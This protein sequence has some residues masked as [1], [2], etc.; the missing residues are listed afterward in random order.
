MSSMFLP[1]TSA[2]A[3]PSPDI[4]QIGPSALTGAGSPLAVALAG[5]LVSRSSAADVDGSGL[6][7]RVGPVLV[8]VNPSPPAGTPA[9]AHAPTAATV[10]SPAVLWRYHTDVER[11]ALLD[12]DAVA[13][14]ELRAQA[15]SGASSSA[16]A[17]AAAAAK[18]AA[19]A[20]HVFGVA[21]NALSAVIR[22]Y[23]AQSIVIVGDRGSGKRTSARG[24]LRYVTAVSR[25]QSRALA[26]RVASLRNAALDAAL[27]AARV[28]DPMIVGALTADRLAAAAARAAAA[29]AAATG[30][31]IDCGSVGGTSAPHNLYTPRSAFLGAHATLAATTTLGAR[32]SAALQ[33]QRSSGGLPSNELAP[34]IAALLGDG[35]GGSA[36]GST[37]AARGLRAPTASAQIVPLEEMVF[38]ALTVID[39]FSCVTD[40]GVGGGVSTRAA[41]RVRLDV[42][43][44]GG[45]LEGAEIDAVLYDAA[46]VA[47]PPPAVALDRAGAAYYAAAAASAVPSATS[48]YL[49]DGGALGTTAPLPP[50]TPTTP[51]SAPHTNFR[52]FY[53]LL[54]PDALVP[55]S[56]FTR[57]LRLPSH[58]PADYA[59]LA[60]YGPAACPDWEADGG[61]AAGPDRFS[62]VT[63]PVARTSGGAVAAYLAPSSVDIPGRN[64]THAQRPLGPFSTPNTAASVAHTAVTSTPP[65]PTLALSSIR[66]EAAQLISAL[67][68]LGVSRASQTLL[69]RSL[70]AVLL[71]GE[72][73]WTAASGV[74]GAPALLAGAGAPALAPLASLLGVAPDDLV[75]ALARATPGADSGDAGAGARGVAPATRAKLGSDALGV[76]LFART[77]SAL[78]CA[79]NAALAGAAAVAKGGRAELR[80][81]LGRAAAVLGPSSPLRFSLF[82]ADG[83]GA[84]DSVATARV[85]SQKA[86]VTIPLT[87]ISA[88]GAH[89]P[90]AGA[91]RSV[92]DLAAAASADAFEASYRSEFFKGMSAGYNEEGLLDTHPF[93]CALAEGGGGGASHAHRYPSTRGA[94]VDLSRYPPRL[95]PRYRPPTLLPDTS[96]S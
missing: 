24:V 2:F 60:A 85:E 69:W 57:M 28:A 72:L 68:R 45:T 29:T 46:R 7:S 22:G 62:D 94:A 87:V 41:T 42:A 18:P 37:A 4:A 89:T 63:V 96:S 90:T 67:D 34:L 49:G 76:A 74:V 11:A 75:V 95:F 10:F 59:F 39:A 92:S 20:P 25:A 53:L 38:D 9:P 64:A 91:V 65:A 8:A 12:G 27:R 48:A 30:D 73:E 23:G 15:A 52:I 13:M 21:A 86:P 81:Q 1:P 14:A 80:A 51:T 56:D 32:G 79:S 78:V 84:R 3:S 43:L 16:A 36:Q 17:A 26:A 44:G 6:F 93:L 70:A 71:C 40:G 33:K 54:A 58:R 5:L 82:S 77:F 31:S 55:A 66:A 35:G 88:P 83:C 47:L 50:H 19:L 61:G